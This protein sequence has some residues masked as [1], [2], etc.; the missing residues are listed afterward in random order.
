MVLRRAFSAK[1]AAVPQ[2]KYHLLNCGFA[3]SSPRLHLDLGESTGDDTGKSLPSLRIGCRRPDSTPEVGARFEA[4]AKWLAQ[5]GVQLLLQA[6]LGSRRST[7][8]GSTEARGFLDLRR[9][10]DI[11]FGMKRSLTSGALASSYYRGS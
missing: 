1:T 11:W 4:V 7:Q 2:M 8:G 6:F 3:P 9:S 5:D 10:A